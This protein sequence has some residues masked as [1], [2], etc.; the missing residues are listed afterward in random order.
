MVS[1]DEQYQTALVIGQDT[2]YFW[3]LSRHKTMPRDQLHRLLQKAQTMD[4]DLNK[5]ILVEQE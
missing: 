3:L 5:V 1:L 4:V 2:R